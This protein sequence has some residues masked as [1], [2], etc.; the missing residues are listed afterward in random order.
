VSWLTGGNYTNSGRVNHCMECEELHAVTGAFGYSG[1]YIA[2]KLLARGKR[3]MTLT[4]SPRRRN[5][6]GER[7]R[8]AGFNFEKPQEL[9][10]S[11]SGVSV[12][13]NTYWVRFN[14]KNFTHA[15]AVINTKA[16][17]DAAKAAGVGRV[18]HISI[19]NPAE[20]SKT[21]YFRCKA[22]IERMLKES[23]LSYAI[24]RPA[25]LFGGEDILINNIAWTLRHFPV[26]GMFG[27]GKYKLQ[28]IYVEDLAEIAVRQASEAENCVIDA[29]GP[30]S[31]EYRELVRIIGRII[32]KERLI[33]PMPV[34]LGYAAA[35]VV[36][37]FVGDVIVTREEIK[38]LMGNYLYADSPPAGWTKLTDWAKEHSA[39][40]GLKYASELKRRLDRES[41]YAGN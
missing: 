16:L 23:G 11:L 13:F 20:D 36:G 1:R 29:I 15:D 31:F 19:L 32:G 41:E 3:V 12:L 38:G 22:Q 10:H 14:H 39:T 33:L 26:F 18:V 8:V 17:F 27:D 30:E 28:P 21:E 40:L 5:P 25:V 24:L 4:N 7:V 35:C 37:R 2:E 6:F 9:A 34:I